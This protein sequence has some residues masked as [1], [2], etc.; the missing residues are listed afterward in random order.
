MMCKCV[1]GF[2]EA[3]LESLGNPFSLFL[4]RRLEKSTCVI[5]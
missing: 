4:L 5:M 2:G 3:F 1:G